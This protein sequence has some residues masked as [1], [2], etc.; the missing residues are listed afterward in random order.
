M[1]KMPTNLAKVGEN[2]DAQ[3]CD[4]QDLSSELERGKCY[5]VSVSSGRP[6]GGANPANLRV[7]Y[8]ADGAEGAEGL[9]V[10]DE[11]KCLKK[12]TKLKVHCSIG[13]SVTYSLVECK[14]PG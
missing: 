4:E 1:V 9:G 10:G 2:R 8:T 5:K 3:F 11:T 14:C 13:A 7:H 6:K 12:L